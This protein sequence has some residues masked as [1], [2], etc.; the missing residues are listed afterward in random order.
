MAPPNPAPPDGSPSATTQTQPGNGVISSGDNAEAEEVYSVFSPSTRTFLTYHLGF[1]MLVSTLTSTIYS[2]LIPLLATQFSVSI[3]AINTTVTVY[4]IFQAASPVLLSSLADSVGR[5]PTLLGILTL[6]A[7]ASLGLSLNRGNYRVLLCLR[8]LQSIGGSATVPIA[9]GIVADVAV[10]SQRGRMLGPMLATC[11]AICAVSPIVGGALALGTGGY[12]WVFLTLL[13]ISLVLIVS[14]GFALPETGRNVVGNGS[15]PARG[16]WR[17]WWSFVR[18]RADIRKDTGNTVQG[19]PPSE[20][21]HLSWHPLHGFASLRIIFY[22]DAATVLWTVATSYSVYYTLQVA[23]PVIFAEVYGNNELEIGLSLLPV[24][25]GLTLGGLVAGKL[26][27]WNYA[28]VAKRH[29]ISPNREKSGIP[30]EFPLEIAR[31]RRCIPFILLETALIAGYGWAVQYRVHPSVPLILHFFICGTSTILTHISN[32]LLVDIFPGMPSTAYAAGQMMRCGLSAASV[33]VLQPIIDAV[34]RGWYFT[35][36][37]SFVGLSGLAS[38]MV[39]RRKGMQ[40]RQ[41]RQATMRD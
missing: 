20:K 38:V 24:F 11:N 37:A 31:Y 19:T 18:R 2:P 16:I 6:Y 5:R 30:P 15:W 10:V 12:V 40:W 29:N 25:A 8:A 36:F 35:I 21:S 13:I 7:G 23:V 22:P 4:A 34:G 3:Q 27:D 33:A 14:T 32:A 9:Y 28:K 26:I 41:K 17:T 39:S 1:V